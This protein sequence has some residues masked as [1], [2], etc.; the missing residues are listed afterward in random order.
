MVGHEL[1]RVSGFQ[2]VMCKGGKYSGAFRSRT[3]IASFLRW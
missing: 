3:S 2:D 1:I